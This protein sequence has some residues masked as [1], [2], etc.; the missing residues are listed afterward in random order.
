MT[1]RDFKVEEARL[2]S[3]NTIF[4]L[5]QY[6][7][8]P[9]I[10]ENDTVATEEIAIGDNDQ[11]S[12][13]VADIIEADILV[14]ASD[15]DGLY[16]KNPHLYR[17]AKLINEIKNINKAKLFIQEKNSKLGTGGMTTK[18]EAVKICKK[19]KIEVWIVNGGKPNFLIDAIHGR[20]SFTKFIN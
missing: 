12:A 14:I 3:K 9:I 5:L 16:D 10:N 20:I 11:L 13:H 15:I 4:K 2:N 1:Y 7:Y 6:G 8:I 18:I 17:D 19:K